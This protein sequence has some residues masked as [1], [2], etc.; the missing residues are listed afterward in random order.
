MGRILC[1]N[2]CYTILIAKYS[3]IQDANLSELGPMIASIL[4]WMEGNSS[5][6]FGLANHLQQFH[7]GRVKKKLSPFFYLFFS[8]SFYKSTNPILGHAN[9]FSSSPS[10]IFGGPNT[11]VSNVFKNNTHNSISNAIAH[12]NVSCIVPLPMSPDTFYTLP[13][14]VSFFKK[15]FTLCCKRWW[16]T[17]AR[18]FPLC[19]ALIQKTTNSCIASCCFIWITKRVLICNTI[20]ISKRWWDTLVILMLNL[21]TFFARFFCRLNFKARSCASQ[22]FSSNARWTWRCNGKEWMG[23]WRLIRVLQYECMH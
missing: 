12:S 20:I 1:L 13:L 21:L 6:N 16:Q 3:W 9:P 2:C 8:N 14:F 15:N 23:S 11:L 17:I 7:F 4:F 18:H 19:V 22:G 5:T 10:W